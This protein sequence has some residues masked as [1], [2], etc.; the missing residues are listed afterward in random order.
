MDGTCG[1]HEKSFVE[2]LENAG[3]KDIIVGEHSVVATN[4]Q[5]GGWVKTKDGSYVG[6][7]YARTLN[8]AERRKQGIRL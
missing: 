2:V 7:E 6:V 4:G 1:A 5:F 8:R 3:A